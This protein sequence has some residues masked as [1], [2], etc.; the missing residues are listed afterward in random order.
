MLSDCQTNKI[1][2]MISAA[3]ALRKYMMSLSRFIAALAVQ[4]AFDDCVVDAL[5][6][7][8]LT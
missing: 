6:I 7:H 3:N 5:V 2:F 8:T 1:V 4:G